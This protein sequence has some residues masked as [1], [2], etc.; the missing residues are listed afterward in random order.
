MSEQICW[1]YIDCLSDRSPDRKYGRQLR[2]VTP[3]DL[4]KIWD[5]DKLMSFSWICPALAGAVRLRARRP[6]WL[7]SS[8]NA[9]I[10]L[11]SLYEQYHWNCCQT[12]SHGATPVNPCGGMQTGAWAWMQFKLFR[13]SGFGLSRSRADVTRCDIKMRH[14]FGNLF[15]RYYNIKIIFIQVQGLPIFHKIQNY[16]WS[17]SSLIC[18]PVIYVFGN[19][20]IHIKV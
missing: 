8:V 20:H 6:T 7:V 16:C 9:Q 12:K 4:R 17:R 15:P 18:L 10:S 5:M 2:F 19:I 1:I 11:R 14:L 3:T 13:I